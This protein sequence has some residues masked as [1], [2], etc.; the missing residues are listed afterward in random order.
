[1]LLPITYSARF[2]YYRGNLIIIIHCSQFLYPPIIFR[3]LKAHL[4]M[5]SIILLIVK[6]QLTLMIILILL[7]LS[8]FVQIIFNIQSFG[9]S[10]IW[11][12]NETERKF[13]LQNRARLLKIVIR[14]KHPLVEDEKRSLLSIFK[15]ME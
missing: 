5:Y 4:F 11:S 10:R 8:T 12:F 2:F 7:S 3:K 6:K 9:Y 13:L 14:V 1:M 15:T